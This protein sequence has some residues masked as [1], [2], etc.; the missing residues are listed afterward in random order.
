MKKNLI[1]LSINVSAIQSFVKYSSAQSLRKHKFFTRNPLLV[2]PLPSN[3]NL[4][5]W[6]V[7]ISNYFAHEIKHCNK[8]LCLSCWKTL[9]WLFRCWNKLWFWFQRWILLHKLNVSSFKANTRL[10]HIVERKGFESRII[11]SWNK[12]HATWIISRSETAKGSMEVQR[13]VISIRAAK[14]I[15][16]KIKTSQKDIQMSF[17]F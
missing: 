8:N 14:I 12:A 4:R 13:N 9:H 1:I 10:H 16:I 5:S 3:C 2:V 6:L 17:N 11:Y 7:T 15:I